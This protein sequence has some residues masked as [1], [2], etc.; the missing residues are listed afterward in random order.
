M[1]SFSKGATASGLILWP[2]PVKHKILGNYTTSVNN[3]S[4]LSTIPDLTA[5]DGTVWAI[6]Y[7]ASS[8]AAVQ[9]IGPTG[10]VI[11][12]IVKA[13]INAV[14]VSLLAVLVDY[15]DAKLYMLWS[16]ASGNAPYFASTPLATK[17][18]AVVALTTTF[19]GGLQLPFLDRAG[20]Q[21]AGNLTIYSQNYAGPALEKRDINTSGTLQGT[22]A[23][24]LFGGVT[25][26]ISSTGNIY[27]SQAGNLTAEFS[28]STISVGV[29]P[30]TI[31]VSRNGSIGLLSSSSTNRPIL[32]M[33]GGMY[34]LPIINANNITFIIGFGPNAYGTTVL[35]TIAR[36][37]FDAFLN[38]IA[39]SVGCL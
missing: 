26:L 38:Q 23:V 7:A 39:D 20:G 11:Y 1:G 30:L 25:P 6:D 3:Q 8:T 19:T 37:D 15:T 2:A 34:M 9:R 4:N 18:P 32:G 33:G 29:T 10:A 5:A 28:I 16:G 12:T 36:V 31:R 17:T 13:D 14:A 35:K 27:V 21:G 24:V 22:T